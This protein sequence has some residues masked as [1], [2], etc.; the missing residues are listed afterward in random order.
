MPPAPKSGHVDPEC[1]G[2]Q[3]IGLVMETCSVPG[4]S[5]RL[6]LPSSPL[7]CRSGSVSRVT[8]SLSGGVWLLLP[9]F[10]LQSLPGTLR[11][12]RPEVAQLVG[13]GWGGPSSQ[14]DAHPGLYV[15][16]LLGCCWVIRKW[17]EGARLAWSPSR[18]LGGWRGDMDRASSPGLTHRDTSSR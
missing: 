12:R 14:A 15:K 4:A 1:S 9:A 17:G 2:E 6:F 7:F 8:S 11:T 18:D 3:G 5:S 16:S 13:Q 10:F